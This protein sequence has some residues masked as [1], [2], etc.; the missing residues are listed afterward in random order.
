MTLKVID[1]ETLMKVCEL[2]DID[3][4]HTIEIHIDL[5]EITVLVRHAVIDRSPR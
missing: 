2:L 4:D 3:P 1:I 5:N